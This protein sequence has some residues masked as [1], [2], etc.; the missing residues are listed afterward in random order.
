VNSSEKRR[1]S[2]SKLSLEVILSEASL[3]A[4]SKDL[5]R[6]SARHS[7][8]QSNPAPHAPKRRCQNPA[9]P[10]V[11]SRASLRVEGP[12]I[13]TP[14]PS[15]CSLGKIGVLRLAQRSL[16][17]TKKESQRR[18]AASVR[19]YVA[20][21]I[22]RGGP[23]EVLRLRQPSL[24]MTPGGANTLNSLLQLSWG[25]AGVGVQAVLDFCEDRRLLPRQKSERGSAAE[26]S[27]PALSRSTPTSFLPRETGEEV[28]K[29]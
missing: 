21:W 17:M 27:H 23:R 18:N 19:D 20:P 16:R 15:R 6:S 25:R 7:R 24:R 26:K 2:E 14:R 4:Q 9:S 8:R 11:S 29:A 3:R 5:A 10:C 13:L 12:R 1:E 22:A 28:R